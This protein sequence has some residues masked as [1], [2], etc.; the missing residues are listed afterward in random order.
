MKSSP[1]IREGS[2]AQG[3]KEGYQDA[4]EKAGHHF[5]YEEIPAQV[6]QAR[7]DAL[8]EAIELISNGD[9]RLDTNVGRKRLLDALQSLTHEK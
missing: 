4:S 6:K 3:Y 9:Y 2:R 7:A 1:K 8:A 5:N